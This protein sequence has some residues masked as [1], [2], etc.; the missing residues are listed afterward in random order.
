MKRLSIDVSGQRLLSGQREA[1]FGK[2]FSCIARITHANERQH[3]D[4]TA[5]SVGND[6]AGSTR[7]ESDDTG[8]SVDDTVCGS[9]DDASA[10]VGSGCAAVLAS[11][12]DEYVSL[13][14]L[15]A[16]AAT[17]LVCLG[18]YMVLFNTVYCCLCAV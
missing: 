8:G 1:Y 14:T 4:D 18:E 12:H 15:Q 5:G 2:L 6:D 3:S 9:V 11:M 7:Q 13:Q 17:R 16:W 10:G